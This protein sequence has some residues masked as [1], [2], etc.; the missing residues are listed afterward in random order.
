MTTRIEH[1][2][3]AAHARDARRTHALTLGML[4]AATAGGASAQATSTP[5]LP[6]SGGSPDCNA[7]AADADASIARF[8]A[9]A[10]GADTASDDRVPESDDGAALVA[11]SPAERRDLAA[12]GADDSSLVTLG[13]G[14][15]AV[16]L[17]ATAIGRDARA[18]GD[19]A[20]AIG[21]SSFAAGSASAF[22]NGSYAG[23]S[24][25]IAVGQ[26]AFALADGSIAIGQ[27]ASAVAA[28]AI[29]IG[30]NST[31]FKDS[32]AIGHS[33]STE[34][35]ESVF[36]G[37]HAQAGAS[38]GTGATDPSTNRAVAVGYGATVANEGVAVGALA[39][40]TENG[41]AVGHRAAS[42]A[43]GLAVGTDAFAAAEGATAVGRG[44][45]ASGVR[46][47]ALGALASAGG[48]HAFALGADSVANGDGSI[49]LGFNSIANEANTVSFGNSSRTRR[50]VH[51]APGVDPT[52]G[53]N[54][55]QLHDHGRTLADWMGGGAGFT[56]SGAFLPPTFNMQ[57][58][59]YFTVGT[60][61]EAIDS[62]LTDI[63]VRID[64]L[65]TG[66][67]G[68]DGKSAY[69][70]AIDGGFVG[71]ETEWVASLR[72]ADGVGIA[73]KD[74]RDAYQ[75]AVEDG[76]FQGDRQAWL[77]SL[78]GR[79]GVDAT[80]SGAGD[81]AVQYTDARRSE[82]SL[83]TQ[84]V[85]RVANVAAGA[86]ATD[87]VNVA[88]LREQA[89]QTVRLANSY[90]DRQIG[91]L[92]QTWQNRWD[93]LDGRVRDVDRRVDRVGASSAALTMM[94]SSGMHMEA[95][96]VAAQAGFGMYRNASALAAG[97]KARVSERASLSLGGS[98]DGDSAMGG[99]GFSWIL[100]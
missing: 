29:A 23:G 82:V 17:K 71:S 10:S 22:G 3:R 79:D 61:F 8:A 86:S 62:A 21:S 50:L 35:T 4:L 84:G 19:Q 64:G 27:S 9:V 98:Y 70:S 7:I 74:G 76:G 56:D 60:A 67:P 40:A 45:V 89:E 54:I 75:V 26:F 100:R 93:S 59:R 80:G 90:T 13:P 57:G 39:S 53:V 55:S 12:A 15:S 92:D 91:R 81:L 51:L 38:S 63:N 77:D 72:G 88:Q 83:G 1:R 44:T 46:S 20:S 58:G 78:R 11:I 33:I 18:D 41:I 31:A 25:S 87:A 6:C 36:I 49:A 32:I 28:G 42:Q 2:L 30:N 48:D 14:A 5:P 99:V 65:G 73:G 66:V 34:A 24:R 43:S 52:D 97:L 85:V 96:Q 95:G 94:A 37:A 68:A 16:G 47:L 69:Q